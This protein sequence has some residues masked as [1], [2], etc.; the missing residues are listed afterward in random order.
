MFEELVA[1]H[2]NP[3]DLVM[4]CFSGS[5]TTGAAAIRTGR[6]YIGCEPDAEFFAKSSERLVSEAIQKTSEKQA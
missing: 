6:S 3:G 5:A 1:A 4:D 2:T